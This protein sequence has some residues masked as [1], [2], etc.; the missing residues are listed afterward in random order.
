MGV[1]EAQ[2]AALLDEF[3]PACARQGDVHDD[4]VGRACPG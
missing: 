3:Q 1:F 4:E 2:L